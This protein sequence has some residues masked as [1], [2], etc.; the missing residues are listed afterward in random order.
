MAATP[1]NVTTMGKDM[2]ERI[3]LLTAASLM[4]LTSGAGAEGVIAG[5]AT[6]IRK[7]DRKLIGPAY[8]MTTTDGR[9]YKLSAKSASVLVATQLAS[10]EA[11]VAVPEADVVAVRRGT[12]AAGAPIIVAAVP[13]GVEAVPVVVIE[14]GRGLDAGTS[15]NIFPAQ[16]VAVADVQPGTAIAVPGGEPVVKEDGYYLRGMESDT[17]AM[18]TVRLKDGRMVTIADRVQVPHVIEGDVDF[19]PAALEPGKFVRLVRREDGSYFLGT[20]S[21]PRDK[22]LG[23]PAGKVSAVDAR[24][25]VIQLNDGGLYH[26]VHRASA[27]LVV[28]DQP[29]DA[30][31]IRSGTWVV[32]DSPSISVESPAAIPADT[33]I[34]GQLFEVTPRA[35]AR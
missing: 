28:G 12:P 4:L 34:R 35:G 27:V 24:A 23:V 3:T 9:T 30:A 20:A 16:V 13:R 25:Q 10:P 2:L 31:T 11:I 33:I 14:R 5:K 21:A 32:I 18:T 22:Y 7:L 29:A 8:Y 6:E 1:T 15:A 17:V 19:D 26:P